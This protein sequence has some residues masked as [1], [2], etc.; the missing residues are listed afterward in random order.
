MIEDANL[1]ALTGTGQKAVNA[2]YG[3]LREDMG[4]FI[5]AQSGNGAKARWKNANDQLRTMIGDLSDGAFKRTLQKAETTPE[6]AAKLIFSKTPSEVKRLFN[7]L[8][9][10]GQAKG[11][12]ALIQKAAEGAIDENGVISPQKFA[13]GLDA[14]DKATGVF[15]PEVEKARI[16]GVSRLLKATQHASEAA[17]SPLTGAQNT[18]LL[19]GAGLTALFGKAVI[20]AATMIGLVARGY[21]SGP[22]RDLLLRL[23][24]SKPGSAGEANVLN[25]LAENMKRLAPRAAPAA[26]NNIPANDIGS[27]LSQSTTAAAAQ[28]NEQDPRR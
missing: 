8:S 7:N 20:P 10:A 22:M 26:V 11:R 14:V 2:V 1:A 12:A 24:R 6:G 19:F 3:P 18:P 28:G 17:A 21:E 27:V 9:P 13:R 15:F 16:D 4:A 5:E 23:G 25:A